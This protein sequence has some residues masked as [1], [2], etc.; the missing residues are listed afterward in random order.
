MFDALY[1]GATGMRASQ[2]DVDAIAHNVANVNTTAFRRNVVSFAEVSRAVSPTGADPVLQ[3]VSTDLSARGA[4]T[5]ATLALSTSQGEL[6]QTSQPLDIAIDGAGFLEVVRA[7]GTPAYTR[8]GAL[9]V[10]SE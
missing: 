9:R 7:D 3:A 2:A 8:A 6:K 5:I 1:I 4:G 10:N